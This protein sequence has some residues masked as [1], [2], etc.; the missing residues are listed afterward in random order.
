MLKRFLLVDQKLP[1][2]QRDNDLAG[3]VDHGASWRFVVDV[4]DL[5][6]AYHIVGPGQ[7]G[8]VKS[9]WYQDQVLDWANGDYHQTFIKQ[10][11][12][13]GKTLQLIAK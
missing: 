2:K 10:E 11:E 13:K 5:S 1:Y 8:H 3:N 6:S 9:D 12:I 7:S 4:G